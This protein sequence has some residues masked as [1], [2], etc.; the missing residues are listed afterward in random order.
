MALAARDSGAWLSCM[1]WLLHDRKKAFSAF[2]IWSAYL[3]PSSYLGSVFRRIYF[4][5]PRNFVESKVLARM[6]DPLAIW[7]AMCTT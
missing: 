6:R 4:P 7:R 5:P 2:L 1:T 3:A